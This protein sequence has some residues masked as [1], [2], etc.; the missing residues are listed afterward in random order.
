[1]SV[2]SLPRA[3]T[4]RVFANPDPAT[5]MRELKAGFEEFKGG[6]TQKFQAA[7]DDV[8]AKIA[9]LTVGGGVGPHSALPEDP[10]YSALFANWSRS[11][12]SDMEVRS[13]NMTGDRGANP[14]LDVQRIGRRWWLSR[15]D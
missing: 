13:A 6:T 12:H 14:R 4:S 7:L 9:A 1:M 11:G 5:M 3:I 15:P 8:N 2:R 10:E